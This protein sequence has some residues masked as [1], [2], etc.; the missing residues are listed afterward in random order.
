MRQ[1]P[2]GNA[3]AWHYPADRTT[4]LWECYLHDRYRQS[5]PTSDTTLKLVWLG[6]ADW[7]VDGFRPARFVTP[8]REDLYEGASWQTFL[9]SLGYEPLGHRAFAK[10]VAK[11]KQP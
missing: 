10:P 11:G 3:Q 7:L 1:I 8:S 9:R 4:V 6:L 2:I 5:E